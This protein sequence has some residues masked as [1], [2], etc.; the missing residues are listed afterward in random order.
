ME[1]GYLSAFLAKNNRSSKQQMFCF[2][3]FCTCFSLQTLQFFVGGGTKY[4]CPSWRS[5]G[6]ITMP[7]PV[8]DRGIL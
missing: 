5:A 7:L 3:R 4:L 1:T 8:K 6:T 2:P